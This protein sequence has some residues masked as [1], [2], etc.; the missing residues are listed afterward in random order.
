M[1]FR[2]FMLAARPPA[3]HDGIPPAHQGLYCP[4]LRRLNFCMTECGCRDA[5]TFALGVL[6]VSLSLAA[7]YY[8]VVLS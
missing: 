1:I 4:R 5:A 3:A 7:V 2:N 8:I 6:L